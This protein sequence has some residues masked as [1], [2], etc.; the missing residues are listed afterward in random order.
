[1]LYTI[2]GSKSILYFRG[3]NA[4]TSAFDEDAYSKSMS[5]L[6]SSAAGPQG[7]RLYRRA[8]SLESNL[9]SPS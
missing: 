8:G 7:H 5:K 3:T 9:G 4:S 2:G 1:M 6:V